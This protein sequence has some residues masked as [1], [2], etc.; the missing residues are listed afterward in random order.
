[1]TDL[2]RSRAFYERELGLALRQD[3]YPGAVFLAADGYHHHIAVNTWAR[4]RRPA[5]PDAVGLV[6]IAASSSS[7][8]A[9][10]QLADP[11]GI[12]LALSP[13]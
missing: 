1:M 6:E 7:V 2:D 8:R 13:L 9:P 4:T 11:D 10:Q 5:S 12:R 3:D